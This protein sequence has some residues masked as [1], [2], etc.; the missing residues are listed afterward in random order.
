MG[1]KV[2]H[3][4]SGGFSIEGMDFSSL[5]NLF[6]MGAS[7]SDVPAGAGISFT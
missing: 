2:F 4:G 3:D 7:G 6:G 1:G 5:K